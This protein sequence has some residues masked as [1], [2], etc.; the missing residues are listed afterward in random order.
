MKWLAPLILCSSLSAQA[1]LLQALQA[2]EKKDYQTA[3]AKFNE[4]LPFGNELA[5][6]NL[7]VMALNGEGQP[8]D[9][10]KALAYL[11][12]AIELN[13][14]DAAATFSQLSAKSTPAELAAAQQQFQQLQPQVVIAQYQSEMGADEVF[15]QPEPVKYAPPT[16]PRD[17]AIKGLSG[18]VTIRI[19]VGRDGKIAAVDTLDAYPKKVFEKAAI[20]AM[21]KWR[22][23]ADGKL[24]VHQFQL[25]F[26]LDN[27]LNLA[28]VDKM[29]QDYQLWDMAVA[30]SSQHQWVLGTL[31]QMAT[32][33]S[34]NQFIFDEK[35]P[36]S[37]KLELDF[38]KEQPKVTA[39]F[40]DF[41]G[42]AKVSV[43]EQGIITQVH[44]FQPDAK[45]KQPELLG[46]QLTGQVVAGQYNLLASPKQ[47]TRSIRIN[48]LQPAPISLSSRFWWSE[49]AKN[50]DPDA[51][52][53]MA[54]FNK[55]W[56]Q[57][58]INQQDAEVMAWSGA[59]LL[60]AGKRQQGLQLLDQAIA[61]DY[62][63]ASVIKK[64]FI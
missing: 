40:E 51:Q 53:V 2:Y 63:L 16:Y 60:L 36:L 4:L 57:H 13:H 32:V 43:N 56:E 55:D 49:A 6:F 21:K 15:S 54:T 8:K 34:G 58:L 11:M 14:P 31:L 17:A 12:L 1:D 64:H 19:L 37:D 62:P 26:A 7:A 10:I 29:N 33:K 5:S 47:S 20:A 22:Y 30:G 52:R 42:Y 41:Y 18:Y 39:A 61:K 38:F 48:R 46:L 28:K 45:N 44:T 50:G 23:Q 25:T 24:H 3:Q 27:G 35:L 9:R 59:K